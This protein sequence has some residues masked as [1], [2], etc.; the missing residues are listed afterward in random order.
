MRDQP[1]LPRYR[2]HKIVEAVKIASVEIH[3]D[4]SATIYPAEPGFKPFRTR[5]GWA[6]RFGDDTDDPGYFV[7]YPDGYTSWSP[8]KAFEEGYTR[9]G[10]DPAA[11]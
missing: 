5:E 9:I 4:K 7:L 8:T 1:E 10:G 11:S 6:D 3:R 2:S